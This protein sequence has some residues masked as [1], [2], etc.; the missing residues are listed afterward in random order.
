MAA[1]SKQTAHEAIGVFAHDHMAGVGGG[2]HDGMGVDA[3]GNVYVADYTSR[4]LFRLSPEGEK[5]VLVRWSEARYGHGLAWGSGIGGFREDAIYL[6]QPFD[7][8]TVVEVVVGVPSA[9]P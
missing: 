2:F 8:N 9:H 6:P 7:G 4:N 5:T 1:H 3:C